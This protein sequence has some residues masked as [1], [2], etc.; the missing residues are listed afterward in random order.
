VELASIAKKR[1][2]A[3]DWLNQQWWRF[4]LAEWIGLTLGFLAVV[5]QEFKK[6]RCGSAPP[7]G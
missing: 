4:A 5:L 3:S 6:R 1:A 2:R 7:S